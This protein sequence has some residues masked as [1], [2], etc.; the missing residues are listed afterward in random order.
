MEGE[1]KM[2]EGAWTISVWTGGDLIRRRK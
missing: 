2:D 1:M